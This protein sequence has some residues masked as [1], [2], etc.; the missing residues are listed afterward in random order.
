MTGTDLWQKAEALLPKLKERAPKC[1]ELRRLPDET[2]RDFHDAQLFRIHQPKRVGG[3][4]LEFAAV[5]T[6]GALF[7]RVCASTVVELGQ[8]RRA[9]HDARHVPAAGAGRDLGQVARRADRFVVRVPGRQGAQG[10][11]RLHALR[12]LAV[13]ERRRPERMEHARRPRAPGRQPAARAAH[14]PGAALA[15]QGDR[16]LVRRR[17]ARHRQ[18]GRGGERGVRARAHDARGGRHQGRA[19][20]GQRGQSRDAVPASGVRAV[21]L[22]A[23]R[24]GARH[25]RRTDRRLQAGLREDDRRPRRRDPEH[26]DPPCRSHRLRAHLAPGAARRT[27]AKPRRSCPT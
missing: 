11:G 9:P 23:F 7:A 15:V 27:A 20:A 17:P 22:H 1:E 5:V 16:H 6:Y 19:D 13:L 8:L 10:A 2:L 21:S 12:P 18:Q 14:L 25:R 24:R 26:A 4:E 3:A